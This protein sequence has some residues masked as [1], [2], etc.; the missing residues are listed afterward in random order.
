MAEYYKDLVKGFRITCEYEDWLIQKNKDHYGRSLPDTKYKHKGV[1]F[2]S[3]EGTPISAAADG[4]VY[5]VKHED[6]GY[7]HYV[8]LQHKDQQ[9]KDVYTIYAQMR[10][11]SP[12]KKGQ[13][14]NKM[15]TVGYVGETGNA[16]GPH[17]HFEI[18][19]DKYNAKDT[20]DPLKYDLSQLQSATNKDQNNSS[21]NTNPSV[22][23]NTINSTEDNQDVNAYCTPTACTE[24]QLII[25]II[26][27]DHPEGQRIYLTDEKDQEIDQQPEKEQIPQSDTTALS[28]LHK[29]GWEK[30]KNKERHVYLEIATTEGEPIKLNLINNADVTEK[31]VDQQIHQIV[32]I[33]PCTIVKGVKSNQDNGVPVI[34]RS[35][36]LYIF[37]NNGSEKKLWRELQIITKDATT[38]VYKDVPIYDE[39]YYQNDKFIGGLRKATGVELK[40]IWI[41]NFWSVVQPNNTK[42]SLERKTYTN[43]L[44]SEV[45]L[46]APRLNRLLNDEKQL[47]KHP[48]S[49]IQPITFNIKAASFKNL[50][51][52]GKQL[53]DSYKD[54]DVNYVQWRD[55]PAVKGLVTVKNFLS[56]CYP[57]TAVAP[58]RQRDVDL[59]LLLIHPAN[60]LYDL[61][62]NYLEQNKQLAEKFLT[63][64]RQGTKTENKHR[65]EFTMLLPEIQNKLTIKKV[66]EKQSNLGENSPVNTIINETIVNVA[67]SIGQINNKPQDISQ[68][69]TAAENVLQDAHDR[70][71]CCI[72]VEDLHFHTRQL[73]TSILIAHEL[74]GASVALATEQKYCDSA[75]LVQRLICP[76]KIGNKPNPFHENM[77]KLNQEGL[78]QLAIHS[79]AYERG[80]ASDQ[81]NKS[82]LKLLETFTMDNSPYMEIWADHMSQ[83]PKEL[84]A[85]A[86]NNLVTTLGSL[87]I[88]IARIDPFNSDG[89][90]TI[91]NEHFGGYDRTLSK[92]I[93]TFITNSVQTIGSPVYQLLFSDLDQEAL[94]KPYVKP[95]KPVENDG[96]GKARLHLLAECRT[97]AA[98][99][100]PEE[101]KQHSYDAK[102]AGDLL[103]S[104]S[105]SDLDTRVGKAF[106]GLIGMISGTLEGFI[107][108][109][110]SQLTQDQQA[111]AQSQQDLNQAANRVQTATQAEQTAAQQRQQ[112]GRAL[113]QAT[114]QQQ[115]ADA[116]LNQAQQRQQQTNQQVG[117]AQQTANQTAQQ[118]GQRTAQV[119]TD[120]RQVTAA[121]EQTTTATQAAER[122]A[123]RANDSAQTRGQYQTAYEQAQTRNTQVARNAETTLNQAITT[124]RGVA[125]IQLYES[126]SIPVWQAVLFQR[127]RE[128]MQDS[129]IANAFYTTLTRR[130]QGTSST[131]NVTL[132]HVNYRAP[133]GITAQRLFGEIL[134]QTIDPQ[135]GETTTTTVATSRQT[136]ARRAGMPTNV[137][138]DYVVIAAFSD[139]AL[140]QDMQQIEISNRQL[141]QAANDLDEVTEIAEQDQ[142]ALNQARSRQQAA[143]TAE[144]SAQQRLTQSQQNLDSAI[145]ANSRAQAN[146]NRLR[147][148]QTADSQALRN[149]QAMAAASRSNLTQA[150]AT[151]TANLTA[152]QQ[153]S[154]QLTAANAHYNQVQ[155]QVQQRQ[156]TVN[157]SR[158][159]HTT[160]QN[161]HLAR[162]LNSLTV[163]TAILGFQSY[164]LY[165]GWQAFTHANNTENFLRSLGGFALSA[166]DV[167]I[168]FEDLAVRIYGEQS[169]IA[170]MRKTFYT[171][172]PAK[173]PAI[174][175]QGSIL[176]R[177]LVVT[178]LMFAQV[179]LGLIGAA[180]SAYDLYY[181][182]SINENSTVISAAA[183]S[184]VG[185]LITAFSPYLVGTTATFLLI[186]PIGWIGLIITAIA[187]GVAYYFSSTDLELWL[188]N[189]PFGDPNA[190]GSKLDYLKDPIDAYYQLLNLFANI[191]IKHR[192]KTISM[193]VMGYAGEE[194]TVTSQLA[195][196]LGA[197]PDLTVK[198]AY[199]RMLSDTKLA[200]F[201]KE[202]GYPK[203]LAN[204]FAYL[205]DNTPTGIAGRSY[206]LQ[207]RAQFKTKY[208]GQEFYFPAPKIKDKISY[209]EAAKYPLDFD[210][211]GQPFWANQD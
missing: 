16:T 103:S 120:Q 148:Q 49:Y 200:T 66:D 166:T 108:E 165:Q 119:N 97:S 51:A 26:G 5:D 93:N 145:N 98:Q 84:Y 143:Q 209:K 89:A 36:F 204:G 12:L 85:P 194:V 178:R 99:I 14:V 53:L 56:H 2:A 199:T 60:Y 59:E 171:L 205:I 211:T 196:L 111:L 74:L 11:E 188:V 39:K 88:N 151:H 15:Q 22:T 25:Q 62:N 87:S 75:V 176:A 40:E 106:A 70:Q 69:I 92:Q 54:L 164:N 174:F 33:V 95:K 61:E 195:G 157:T 47:K 63:N 81:Y 203:K 208:K 86:Y 117:Q 159:R 210:K 201:S 46:S 27:K 190:T 138:R 42:A 35:G 162:G 90:I 160:L 83:D 161:S 181:S 58:H 187:I 41:P 109:A 149:A 38:T 140:A 55:A 189:G 158:T 130:R 30:H 23:T 115:T 184:V 133:N 73:T 197:E 17:V 68:D 44:Y 20:V 183:L 163:K 50:P 193:G 19:L 191:N 131:Q 79:C 142:Q 202:Q 4:T 72:T 167:L 118:V 48:Q 91:G 24:D 136:T 129:S 125:T 116:D 104:G 52:K 132:V 170:F 182:I 1:D 78:K 37:E 198:A 123:E 77:Q 137:K 207:I 7:G 139:S 64:S 172:D 124:G 173:L 32:P 169:K 114:Q 134:D 43:Y 31:Q 175:R 126:A 67:N 102:L 141:Q 146:L 122:A 180:F 192:Y 101:Y 147:T 9:D 168:A 8:V 45:Q 96:T 57:A 154:Q 185:S 80:L 113:G 76:E 153:A 127:T 105:L 10:E 155:A 112:S 107:S 177:K 65:I 82:Q 206:S 34:A 156:Q 152:H 71:I 121:T 128:V 179:S 144:Q 6:D 13:T 29:W 186:N 100:I 135:T 28:V 94:K 21:A 3:S 110:F 150:Q 18:R